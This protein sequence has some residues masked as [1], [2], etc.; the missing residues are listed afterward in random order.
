MKDSSLEALCVSRKW[1]E[2]KQAEARQEGREEAWDLARRIVAGDSDCYSYDEVYDLFGT[3]SFDQILNMPVEDALSKDKKFQEEKALQVG[4]EVEFIAPGCTKL[5]EVLKG[6]VI[7]IDEENPRCPGWV[8]ILTKDGSYCKS[9]AMCVKT[10][11]HNPYV[12]KLMASF[13]EES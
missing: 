4:D 2:K 8:S 6:Y 7:R 5:K 3:R 1:S 10:G 13:E 12:E 11:K 9:T